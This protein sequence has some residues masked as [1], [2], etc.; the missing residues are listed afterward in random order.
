MTWETVLPV[1]SLFAVAFAQPA[2][3]SQ[4]RRS[5]N[6]KQVVPGM[7]YLDGGTA[8]GLSEGMKL[9]LE[10]LAPGEAK[11]ATRR[12]ADVVVAS[13]ATQSA[14]AEIV[15]PEPGVEAQPGDR[16]ELTGSDVADFDRR[17]AARRRQ[18]YA[19]VISFTS[20]DPLEEE[21]REYVP[22]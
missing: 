12:I 11:M 2:P 20:G 17:E 9:K 14:L 8:H 3:P 10:R 16:A 19:Q 5:F 15:N 21:V 4:A 18:R 6:V 7:V 1:I 13:V 22:M